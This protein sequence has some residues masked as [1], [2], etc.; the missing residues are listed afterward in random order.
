MVFSWLRRGLRTGVVTTRYPAIQERMAD[1]FRGRPVLNA[2]RCVAEQGCDTCVQICLPAA[3]Q[4]RQHPIATSG[5]NGS[6]PPSVQLVLDYTRCIM[7][8]L[9]VADCPAGAL[10]MTGD[11]EL[12]T[13]ARQDLQVAVRF[14]SSDISYHAHEEDD[15]HD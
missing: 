2:R 4:F 3:L 14:L 6:Q 1:E 12:A 10:E 13:R 15:L 5:S 9:C 11:Y 7:C 8:G